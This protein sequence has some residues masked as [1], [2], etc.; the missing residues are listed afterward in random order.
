MGESVIT[1][2]PRYGDKETDDLLLLDG[3]A[4]LSNLLRDVLNLD[5]RVRLDDPKEVLL[6]ESVVQRRKMCTNS[7][8]GRQLY[9]HKPVRSE[10]RG[11]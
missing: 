9:M 3:L 7:D 5:H 4:S 6:Q 8:V 2:S 10:N 11:I 1:V